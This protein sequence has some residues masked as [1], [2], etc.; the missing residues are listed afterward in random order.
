MSLK[1]S[2]S[3]HRR[4]DWDISNGNQVHARY[5]LLTNPRKTKNIV[6]R[7]P[8]DFCVKGQNVAKFVG[9]FIFKVCK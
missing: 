8:K 5:A 4:L 1:G 3:I 6:M 9:N 7:L 2:T